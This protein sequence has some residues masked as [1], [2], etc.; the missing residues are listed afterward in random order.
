M[1]RRLPFGW[2]RW[3]RYRA[4]IVGTESGNRSPV[5]FVRF[6]YERDAALWCVT[7]TNVQRMHGT[8]LTFWHYEEIP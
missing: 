4:V 8:G 6:R 5:D 1:N 7:M 3:H 2:L